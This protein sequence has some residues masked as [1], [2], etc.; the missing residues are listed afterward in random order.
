MRAE[1]RRADLR[2]AE[3]AV[4]Q[5]LEGLAGFWAREYAGAHDDRVGM[6]QAG[7]LGRDGLRLVDASPVFESVRADAGNE[8]GQREV[9]S[10]VQEGPGL[11]VAGSGRPRPRRSANI[12]TA[13]V[14][15]TS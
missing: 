7:L 1:V 3:E 10:G 14:N 11:D 9:R 4:E 15:E 6:A 2:R 13:S 8:P 12:T 5:V